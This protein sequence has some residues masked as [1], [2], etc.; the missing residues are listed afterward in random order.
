MSAEESFATCFLLRDEEDA[1]A[2]WEQ[3]KEWK[4]QSEQGRPIVVTIQSY[5]AAPTPAQYRRYREILNQIAENAWIGK[6][7]KERMP[8]SVWDEH[9]KRLY[10]GME[11]DEKNGEMR[12]MSTKTLGAAAFAEYMQKIEAYAVQEL[13]IE[14]SLR[15]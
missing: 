13:G 4:K 3:L 11:F 12:G 7:G 15:T 8:S 6:D 2:L 9:F 5:D 14:F 1:R 10:I